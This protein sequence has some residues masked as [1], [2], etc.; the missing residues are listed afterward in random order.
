MIPW[1]INIFPYCPESSSS[2]RI[3]ITKFTEI[4]AISVDGIPTVN[5]ELVV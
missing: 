4:Y 1:F 5:D 2:N 3:H